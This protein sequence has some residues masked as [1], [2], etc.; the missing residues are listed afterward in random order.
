MFC[1]FYNVDYKFLLQLINIILFV[2][3]PPFLAVLWLDSTI[4]ECVG[5]H[6]PF[7]FSFFPDKSLVFLD[8]SYL[9]N[10]KVKK[11]FNFFCFFLSRRLICQ[12][13]SMHKRSIPSLRYYDP[14]RVCDSC[15]KLLNPS[16]NSSSNHPEDIQRMATDIS[17][18]S[19]H[20]VE[21]QQNRLNGM[22]VNGV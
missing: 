12:P 17:D 6:V 14:V 4:V 2:S 11:K 7:F 18:S 13:C 21:F 9:N 20:S 19:D 3:P 22:N 1:W 10:N 5:K 15:V 8:Y 16:K